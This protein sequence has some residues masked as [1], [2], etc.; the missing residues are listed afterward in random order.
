VSSLPFSPSPDVGF[1]LVSKLR[2][3]EAGNSPNV[4]LG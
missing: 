1:S 4:C 3:P 2:I